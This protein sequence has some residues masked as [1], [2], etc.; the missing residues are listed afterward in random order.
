MI[1][2]SIYAFLTS[3]AAITAITTRVYPGWLPQQVTTV[4]ALT[5]TQDEDAD[6]ML[7]DG[8]VGSLKS[9]LFSVDCWSESY[10]TSHQLADAVAGE[11]VGHRGA[12]GSD[13]VDH[14]RKERESDLPYESDTGLYRVSL[15]FFIAYEGS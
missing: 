9:A 12:M 1:G 5:Y 13:T 15:Q 8:E 7:L 11:M 4:P 6:Q 10:K 3:R 14:I 2:E